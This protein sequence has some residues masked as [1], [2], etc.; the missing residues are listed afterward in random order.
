[1]PRIVL[2]ITLDTDA[3]QTQVAGPIEN[4]MLV[5]GMLAEAQDAVRDFHRQKSEQRVQIPQAGLLLP[6]IKS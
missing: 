5:Y 4:K 3:N 2:T 1:M 6:G